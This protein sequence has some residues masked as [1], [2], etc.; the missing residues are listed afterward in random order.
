MLTFSST[1]LTLSIFLQELDRRKTEAILALKKKDHL[2]YG[3]YHD[4]AIKLEKTQIYW[5]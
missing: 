5:R 2:G 4:E 3:Y 1:G